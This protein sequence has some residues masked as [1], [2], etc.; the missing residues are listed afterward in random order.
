MRRALGFPSGK[1]I[2]SLF[3]KPRNMVD[4]FI[5]MRFTPRAA[6]LPMSG[7]S[8]ARRTTGCPSEDADATRLAEDDLS[9]P[10]DNM[11]VVV[12]RSISETRAA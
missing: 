3:I 12:R 11:E 8:H 9:L 1:A 10:D 5:G 7:G 4:I 2:I 6:K